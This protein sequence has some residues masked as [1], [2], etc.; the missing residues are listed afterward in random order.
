VKVRHSQVMHYGDIYSDLHG[1]CNIA[2]RLEY[3]S[4]HLI[5]PND[6]CIALPWKNMTMTY[7]LWRGYSSTDHK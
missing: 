4:V 1:L 7:C 5:K 2:V 6:L 3:S